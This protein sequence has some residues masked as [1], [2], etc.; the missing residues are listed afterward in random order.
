M[1]LWIVDNVRKFFISYFCLCAFVPLCLLPV[2]NL[3]E[4]KSLGNI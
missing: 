2:F 1:I 3:S 4:A